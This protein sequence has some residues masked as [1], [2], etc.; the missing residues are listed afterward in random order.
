VV[1]IPTSKGA[2]SESMRKVRR[3]TLFGKVEWWRKAGENW[4]QWSTGCIDER[5]K[6]FLAAASSFHPP[7]NCLQVC[8]YLPLGTHATFLLPSPIFLLLQLQPSQGQH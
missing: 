1:Q 5:R 6:T 3:R 4:H 7:L 8:L 2:L